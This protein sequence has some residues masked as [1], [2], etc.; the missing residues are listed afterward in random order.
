MKTNYKYNNMIMKSPKGWFIAL[1]DMLIVLCSHILA[2][3]ISEYSKDI[4][5]SFVIK[6]AMI[7]LPLLIVL[8]FLGFYISTSFRVIWK[9]ANKLDYL[10][11]FVASILPGII[12]ALIDKYAIKEIKG[13][14][15]SRPNVAYLLTVLFIVAA[16][17]SIRLLYAVIYLKFKN[18]NNLSILKRTLIIGAGETANL[19]TQELLNRKNI[20]NPVCILDDDNIKTTR[21]LQ[22]IKIVGQIED[23]EKTIDEYNIET[24]ILAIPSINDDKKKNILKTCM[25]KNCEI[26]ILPKIDEIIQKL[27]ILKQ[28]RDV[29]IEDLLGRDSIDFDYIDVAKFLENKTILVTGGGGTI[30]SELARQIANFNIKRLVLVDNYENGVYEVQQEI[31]RKNKDIILNVEIISITDKNRMN[32]LFNDY[33]FNVVF[34]AAAHK[35][36]PLM[37]VNPEEAVKN[38]VVGTQIVV[39][40]SSKYNIEKFVLISTDKAVNPTNLMG[41]S[42]RLCEMIVKKEAQKSNKT[43]FTAVRFGN[44]LGSNGSVI[45]LFR[46]QILNGGPV[47]VTDKNIIRYFMTIKE[48]VSLILET[49]TFAKNGEIFI[50]DM[51]EPVKILTLAENMI[52]LMGY[53]PYEQIK[54][55]FTGLRPG[56]KL[57]EEL[58]KTEEG[59]TKTQ[60]GKIFIAKQ[61]P[62]D[63]VKLEKD[64]EELIFEA[65]NNDPEKVVAKMQEIVDTY[66][67]NRKTLKYT[68]GIYENKN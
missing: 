27:D 13:F 7:S 50:L 26:K 4:N 51:G 11:L 65:N 39:E 45:P 44:V 23:L 53:K 48:A 29:K 30:G 14:Y 2:L 67:P 49:S 8:Y 31:L 42:K 25:K 10:L 35:H 36:V 12:F 58:L 46:K 57:Y 18:K 19:V 60:N 47:T 56:E 15:Y 1:I 62:I 24:V 37:E 17:I 33:N 66:K 63:S 64:L 40:L 32:K 5:Y 9:Y 55:E 6:R 3:L 22:G 59:L 38:N 52:K 54:I 61:T 20:Y 41:A 34:H 68:R 16:S 43:K 28:A 21:I